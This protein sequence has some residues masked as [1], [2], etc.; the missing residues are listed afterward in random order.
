[1]PRPYASFAGSECARVSAKATI[2]A[3]ARSD[4]APPGSLRIVPDAETNAQ[5]YAW[6]WFALHAGQRLQLVNFWLVAVAFLAS[7]FVQARSNHLFAIA[8][9]VC[10]T[11]AVSSLAFMRLD[12]RTRQLVEPGWYGDLGHPEPLRDLTPEIFV[13]PVASGDKVV[14]D[15]TDAFFRS[16][17]KSRPKLM[18]VE[19]EGAGVAAAIQDARELS[20]PVGFAMIRGIS[21]IPAD[22]TSARERDLARSQQTDMRD[23]WKERA[24]A[25]AAACA[26]QL[27]RLAWPQ[28]PREQPPREQPTSEQQQ[29]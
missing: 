28:P 26:V 3:S 23:A 18:A 13:G 15:R 19:M 2:R 27:V 14:D 11:G 29:S 5:A 20:R 7:A 8:F 12:V 4:Q 9:G 21:D 25:A 1:M 17:L 6:N 10:V 24:A 22:G 16:V